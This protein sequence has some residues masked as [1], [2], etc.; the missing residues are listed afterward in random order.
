MFVLKEL[1]LSEENVKK[2]LIVL[3]T[4]TTTLSV[5]SATLDMP[6][7]MQI[8]AFQSTLSSLNAQLTLISMEFHAHATSVFSNKTSTPVQHVPLEPNGTDRSV[9]I[10]PLKLALQDMSSTKTSTNVNLQ[11]LHA[12]TMLTSTE[13]LVSA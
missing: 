3:P 10:F 9:T 2:F 4:H 1:S 6:S 5:V 13:L 7:M 12:E 8:C 11:L